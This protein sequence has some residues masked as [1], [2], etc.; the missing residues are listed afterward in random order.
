MDVPS[1]E[2]EKVQRYLKVFQYHHIDPYSAETKSD[3]SLPPVNNGSRPVCTFHTV[4][5]GYILLTEKGKK[6]ENKVYK[7]TMFRLPNSY[8][9]SQQVSS[10]SGTPPNRDSWKPETPRN[11]KI[12]S[13]VFLF[14]LP[15]K[16]ENPSKPKFFLSSEGVRFRGVALY[17]FIGIS[18]NKLFCTL[19]LKIRANQ[20]SYL[21]VIFK[22]DIT[23]Y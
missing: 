22:S 4:W 19:L 18:F 12:L 13:S 7:T 1:Y 11:W 5:P 15:L 3:K 14:K 20:T 9:V 6:T 23:S 2:L 8:K 16:T 10:Y 21:W 17:N